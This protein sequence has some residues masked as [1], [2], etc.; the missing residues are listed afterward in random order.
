MW[1]LS[2]IC[3]VFRLM[4]SLGNSDARKG[5]GLGLGVVG[6]RDMDDA[7]LE[8]G[9]AFSY[10]NNNNNDDYDDA[11]ID[12]D[13]ALSY[14]D[15]KIQ[16]VL[17]HFQKDFEG[18]VSAEN[19]GAKFGGYG[20]FLPTYQRSPVWS[21]P[22]S[23]PKGQSHVPK[24]PNNLHLEGGRS[25]AA[26][27]SSIPQSVG[28]GSTSV[29]AETLPMSKA[30][31]VNDSVKE[32]VRM[33]PNHIN[34]CSTKKYA[35]LPDQKTLRLRI[36]V[37]S[38]NLSTKK[39]AAIYSGLGL[40]I[41]PSSSLDESPSEA[42]GL[43]RDNQDASFESPTNILWVMT[44]FPVLGET[45]LSP[46]PDDVLFLC[47]TEKILK[48]RKFNSGLDAILIREKR[49]NSVERN[50]LPAELKGFDNRDIWND[51]KSLPKKEVDADTL[52]CEE[53]SDTL[54]LP[55]LSN[56]Y[57]TTGKVKKKGTRREKIVHNEGKED[58]FEPIFTQ[59]IDRENSKAGSEGNVWEDKRT[60]VPENV[61]C[62]PRK[63]SL[64]KEEKT[65]PVS[66]DSNPSKGKKASGEKAKDQKERVEQR[67]VSN[68]QESTKLPPGKEQ[69]SSGVKRKSKGSQSHGN[70][71]ADLPKE[72]SRSGGSSSMPKNRKSTSVD[73]LTIK[74]EV[75][76][77]NL[78]KPSKKAEDKYKDFFGDTEESEEDENLTSSVRI[79]S[80]DRLNEMRLQSDDRQNGMRLQSDDRLNGMKIQPDRR[81]NVTE[82]IPEN[83]LAV[84]TATKDKDE[85]VCCDSCQ[86]WR[87]LPPVGVNPS[88]LPDKWLC[89]MLSWLP[90]MNKC[91]IDE[92]ETT[93]AVLA[94]H[95]L[96]ALDKQANPNSNLGNTMPGIPLSDVL[97]P[98]Q[99][100]RS[101]GSL[102]FPVG[103]KK[104][105][106]SKEIASAKDGPAQL[107]QLKK[108][109]QT[110]IRTGS[111][112]DVNHSPVVGE[113]G[114]PH[115][116]R[117]CDLPTE[118]HKHKPKEKNKVLGH[119]SDGGDVKNIKLKGKRNSDQDAFRASKKVKSDNLH[120][121]DD[122]RGSD[123]AGVA[124]QVAFGSVS[125][126]PIMSGR[127][128]KPKFNES[129]SYK[130]SQL[131][132]KD[133]GEVLPK[134]PKDS[135]DDGSLDLMKR[136]GGDFTLK[137]K[138]NEIDN[139]NYPD[140]FQGKELHDG[141]ANQEFSGNR[142]RKEK[143]VRVS[144]SEGK[145]S[146]ACKANGKSDKKGNHTKN[147]QKG[148]AK[149]STP[150]R[151]S[152]DV[153]D[154][155]KRDFGAAQPSAAA[156]TSSSSK[157][158]GSHKSKP[159]FQETKGSP[160]ESVSSSPMRITNPDKL[161][162]PG[163]NFSRRDESRDTGH[164][165]TRSPRKYSDGEDNVGSDRSRTGRKDKTYPAAQHRFHESSV[166]DFQD[167]DASYQSGGQAKMPRAPTPDT[168]KG[169]FTNGSVD[170]MGQEAQ[171]PCKSKTVVQSRNEERQNDSYQLNANSSS[172]RKSVKGSS[173]SKDK[174]RNFKSDSNVELQDS[175]PSTEGK[176]RNGNNK[177][178]ER[179]GIKSNETE[180]RHAEKKES[181]G[182][183][184]SE[185]NKRG[186]Q[187]D[188][189]GHEDP[190][191]KVNPISSQDAK[192]NLKQSLHRD[193]YGERFTKRP[194]LEKTDKGEVVSGRGNRLSLPPSGGAQNACSV[195]GSQKGREIDSSRVSAS[196]GDEALKAPKQIKKADEPNGAQ[197]AS[198]RQPSPGGRM[199][200]QIAPGSLRKESANQA[201]NSAM[202]EAKDLKHLA[203]R[204]KSPGDVAERT[205]LYF[206][207]TLKFLLGASLLE[208][209]NNE[210]GKNVDPLSVY[211]TTAQLC[212][213]VAH[214]Y[215]RRRE[216]ASAALAYKCME[217]AYLKVV[218]S[219]NSRAKGYRT[220]LQTA[221]HMVPPGESPSSS[222]SDVDNLNHPTASDKVSLPKA[223]SSPQVAG[224]VVISARE[225]PSF[226]GLLKFTLD[227]NLA[228]EATRKSRMAFAAANLGET[229]SEDIVSSVKSALD[230]N[231]QDIERFLHLV[232]VA[233][234]A[235]SH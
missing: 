157:V 18:G 19:L 48:D 185:N 161:S 31:P 125:G 135:V 55:F 44:S 138:M 13:V 112:N 114:F 20:S 97:H 168:N 121:S 180:N 190:D 193:S 122:D 110:S 109:I 120:F 69:A 1:F 158:S 108:T 226:D 202:K 167:K 172:P 153:T 41:S 214:E 45:L 116:S 159:G 60:S 84:S 64:V 91:S 40:D 102:S 137:R 210:S 163:K 51:D 85:W 63:D 127:K 106:G 227:I 39:N 16:D 30:L 42:D 155:L 206:Q 74:R 46:L 36:K 133:R 89:S 66:I 104:K 132:E 148:Q 129:G 103:G 216:M 187:A 83:E 15:E 9:E 203:D 105:H 170:Y 184:L 12:P 24:S 145:D 35:N 123:H 188:F 207:A 95:Q 113:P 233:M 96:P 68:V 7:E 177:S 77:L 128:D 117:S 126:L 54:K 198:I 162:L 169:Q 62:Y 223:V 49:A 98:D 52:A 235:M 115:P 119:S 205:G 53:L 171:H 27:L 73:N 81:L 78:E 150:S 208:A 50:N 87:L 23:P 196:Q 212:E 130:D 173:R 33:P 218:Y 178:Q 160:V 38:D 88:K 29:T 186:G 67:A 10:N 28:P 195:S 3:G 11:S 22:R 25:N 182:K 2:S 118:K 144:K 47:K 225:R 139:Y 34:A 194:Q 156:A 75:G 154:S 6:G 199:K 65:D 92:E 217:V 37:G 147:P 4:I 86:K 107:P 149:G 166:F 229:K 134:R 221:L 140:S 222:A 143:K 26:V 56:P 189:L 165:S 179:F 224:H 175:A 131:F 176:H 200:D 14:I 59:E 8:E 209:C 232:R 192:G 211:R 71:A 191:E 79:Q 43:Y 5:L 70:A 17:G 101:N 90:G 230:F 204:L 141:V 32:E 100:H 164:L 124:D 72:S 201:A 61:S 234:E 58:L 146:G 151:S 99:N 213:F 93:K 219:S 231:F 181:G 80:D 82:R 57:S 76:E 215:E 220:E 183:L 136:D 228:M 21:R 174:N 197:K 111:L 94:L 142:G 152:L